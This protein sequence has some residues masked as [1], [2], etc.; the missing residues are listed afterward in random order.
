MIDLVGLWWAEAGRHG[1]LPL[2][3]RFQERMLGRADL[4][5]KK[6][7]FTFYPGAVRIPES[8][9]P[10]TKNRSWTMTVDIDIGDGGATGPIVAMGGD[11]GGW[12]LYLKGGIP[13]FCYNFCAAELS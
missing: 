3:D 12:S 7:K 6:T 2:D 8:S 4:R 13:M 11:T 1:V 5:A 10:D 9:A